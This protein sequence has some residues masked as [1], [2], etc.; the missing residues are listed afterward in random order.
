MLS[1]RPPMWWWHGTF[2]HLSDRWET[3]FFFPQAIIKKNFSWYYDSAIS[4]IL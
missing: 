1:T 3:S 2:S 4:Q